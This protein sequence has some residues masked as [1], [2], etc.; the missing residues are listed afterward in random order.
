VEPFLE[1][2]SEL[3]LSGYEAAVYL[4][5]LAR[6]GLTP[7]E[8]AARAKVPRQ[9]IYDVLETLAR[10][11]L[12]TSRDTSPRTFFAVDPTLALEGLSQQRAAA[13]EREREKT[14]R[15][16]QE[17]I[18]ELLPV[19][20]AGRGQND[21]LAYIEVLSDPSRI[22]TRALELARSA[23]VSVNSCIKRP[24]ILSQE[25]NWRFIREPLERGVLYRALYETSAVEEEELREWMQTFRAWGQQIRL[26]PELPVKM[27]AFD[28]AAALLSMQDP[29]GGPP[30]FTALAIQHRGTV[31]FLNMA[32]E[33]LW[34]QGE[35]LPW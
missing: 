16:A 6:G 4:A 26:V 9:R 27:N 28:D 29:V 32:F 11:G 35:P 24:L 23:Q 30:S 17:L 10:K 21:P 33:H 25:Q 12:C 34:E 14:A 13:L 3:G 7:T 1:A 22:A 19:F 5:L 31:A 18:G 15:K 2:L 20:Q 8:L